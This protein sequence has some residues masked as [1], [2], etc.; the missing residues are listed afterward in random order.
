MTDEM[1]LA[2]VQR[3]AEQRSGGPGVAEAILDEM[4]AWKKPTEEQ[5]RAL[6]KLEEAQSLFS[7][8]IEERAE[9]EAEIAAVPK[10]PDGKP[11]LDRVAKL[12]KEKDV[13][14][15]QISAQAGNVGAAKEAAELAAVDP[16][17][18]MRNAFKNSEERKTVIKGATG[19][20]VGKVGG[21][22]GL[23]TPP[24]TRPLTVDHIVAID[25]ISEM[26]GFQKLTPAERNM[27]AV[28]QDNLIAMDNSANSSKGARPW[29]QWKQYSTFYDDLT[30][31]AMLAKEAELRAL[32][33]DWIKKQ[34]KGR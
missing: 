3:L 34:V 20:A 6:S 27:L 7:T 10:T 28:R 22:G 18:L 16:R 13:L 26:E 12:R 9:I 17:E 8:L 14:T 32:I 31:E 23:K 1:V 2:Y 29:A 21:G 25:Q 5:V 15:R 19:D 30:K 11:D 33:Q 4:K 24:S